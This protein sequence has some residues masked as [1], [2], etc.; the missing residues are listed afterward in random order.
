MKSTG[1]P[2]RRAAVTPWPA[3]G[4]WWHRLV[5][6]HFISI[7]FPK[8]CSLL[9]LLSLLEAI[10]PSSSS[11][12]LEK[13]VWFYKWRVKLILPTFDIF[14][15]IWH[16]WRQA[17]LTW[18]GGSGD[19]RRRGLLISGCR[20]LQALRPLNQQQCCL[21]SSLVFLLCSRQDLMVETSPISS[22]SRGQ[23]LLIL[24]ISKRPRTSTFQAAGH[25]K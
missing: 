1:P 3:L 25:L 17:F 16:E 22:A 2:G 5:A 11:F 19:S 15:G 21:C 9:M 6:L 7:L 4:V 10:R 14:I 12:E 20:M 8:L 18:N 13:Y 24:W 23:E